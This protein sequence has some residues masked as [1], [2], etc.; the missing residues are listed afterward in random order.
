[1]KTIELKPI[2]ESTEDY[3]AMEARI[4]ALLK[5]YIYLPLVAELKAPTSVLQNSLSDVADAIKSG[6]INFY[7]GNFS[8]RF[9]SRISQELKKLGA[10]WGRKQGTWKIPLS[11]LPSDIRTAIAASEDR[12]KRSLQNID[13]K[14][15]QILPEE[16]ADKIK[17]DD[18]FDT[19]LWKVNEDFKKSVKGITVAPELTTA[20][21]KRIASEYTNNLKLYIK[22]W[23]DK[24]V[25]DLRKE[26]QERVFTGL[27]YE[28]AVQ[29]IQKSYGVSQNKAKFLARQETSLLMTKFKQVRY[30][31]AGVK[32]YKWG[33]VTGS[34]NHPVR[35]MHKALEGKVFSWNNPPVT[36]ENGDHNNPGQDYNCRCFARPIVRF[37]E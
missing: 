9:N 35:P 26:M 13:T 31:A 24:A 21:R 33:C 17:L 27:R 23:T 6:R 2:K 29:I 15:S 3:E 28:S 16:I 8:G 12:F 1:M 37:S 11:S 4:I 25:K 14:L 18:L 36:S 5:K 22:D 32:E 10:Q 19:T 34:A 20:D 7:R 30:E